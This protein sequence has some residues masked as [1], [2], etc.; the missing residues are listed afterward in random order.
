MHSN[1]IS[2]TLPT[3]NVID[4]TA[5]TVVDSCGPHQQAN[6]YSPLTAEMEE[7]PLSAVFL[8]QSEPFVLRPT[9]GESDTTSL[10]N[11]SIFGG[12]SEVDED[13]VQSSQRCVLMPRFGG[14]RGLGP[15]ICGTRSGSPE[16][17]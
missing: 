6:R 13:A 12:E 2:N 8:V 4:P 1:K 5:P 3:G 15:S 11:P 16:P 17:T 7:E 14:V 10:E 9:V